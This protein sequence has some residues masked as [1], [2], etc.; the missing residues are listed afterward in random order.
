MLVTERLPCKYSAVA[1][2]KTLLI[3]SELLGNGN[4]SQA[5]EHLTAESFHLGNISQREEQRPGSKT[6]GRIFVHVDAALKHSCHHPAGTREYG[7]PRFPSLPSGAT[8][9]ESEQ[10]VGA[11][12]PLSCECSTGKRN[13]SH[14]HH[15]Y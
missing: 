15:L 13:A 4:S 11:L 8:L 2:R 1:G 3:P 9:G 7:G 10:S 14:S 12:F 5:E 6:H